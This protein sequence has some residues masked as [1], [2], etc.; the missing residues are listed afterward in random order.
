MPKE[1]R[2]LTWDVGVTLELARREGVQVTVFGRVVGCAGVHTWSSLAAPACGATHQSGWRSWWSVILHTRLGIL[3]FAKSP[4]AS[5]LAIG[6][7]LRWDV[8]HRSVTLL[9]SGTVF[10]N[11]VLA[12]LLPAYVLLVLRFLQGGSDIGWDLTDIIEWA[13]VWLQEYWWVM[14]A[15]MDN[16]FARRSVLWL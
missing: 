1:G 12:W 15:F 14:N 5:L 6:H 2:L 10:D 16:G 7:I 4:I 11:A 3:F 8:A 9:A 13:F